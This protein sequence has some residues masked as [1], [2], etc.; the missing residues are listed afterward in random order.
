MDQWGWSREEAVRYLGITMAAG[1]L[2]GGTCFA[3]I[4]PLAKRFDE[5]K[6]LVFAGL[7]PLV[8]GKIVVL[9]MGRE[10]PPIYQNVTIGD[11]EGTC[12]PENHLNVFRWS[13]LLYVIII[14]KVI[15]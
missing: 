8:V 15:C 6:L 4:G 1:G 7:V 2:I 5:R 12:A 10:Y 9:P 14:I 11:E 3:L 13:S